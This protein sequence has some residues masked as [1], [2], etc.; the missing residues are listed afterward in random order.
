MCEKSR[1][2]SQSHFVTKVRKCFQ[3]CLRVYTLLQTVSAEAFYDN[4]TQCHENE[5][6]HY[7]A[8]VIFPELCLREHSL[9]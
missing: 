7:L 9:G 8:L 3:K 1:K 5:P 6:V 2:S 4:N